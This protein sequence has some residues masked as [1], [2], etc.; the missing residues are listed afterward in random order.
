MQ[1]DKSSS[2]T[3]GGDD[4]IQETMTIPRWIT[5]LQNFKSESKIQTKVNKAQ[6]VEIPLKS[7]H[8]Q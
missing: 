4:L 8:N 6:Y 5:Y 2:D 1:T 7:T 3:Q